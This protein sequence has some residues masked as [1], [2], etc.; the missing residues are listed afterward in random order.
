MS[1]VVD[2][3]SKKYHGATDDALK[4]VSFTCNKGILGLLGPNGAGKTTLMRILTTLLRPTSGRAEIQGH[5]V[6]SEPSCV[7]SLIGYVP[8]E[9]QLY[10]HLTAWEFLS[11]MATLSD[12]HNFQFRIEQ[13]MKQV[14]L[15][16]SVVDRR[17]L[18]TFSGGMKQRV[19]IAQALLHQPQVLL[20]DEPTV[21]LDPAE[22]VRFRNM[23][24]ELGQERTVLFSTHIVEDVASTCR[25]LVILHQGR[26][27]FMGEVDNLISLAE[28]KVWEHKVTHSKGAEL[29]RTVHVISSRPESHSGF[30]RLRF[31]LLHDKPPHGAVP[32]DPTIEDAYLLLIAAEG[33][34]HGKVSQDISKSHTG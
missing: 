30:V 20:V 4:E 33:F 19:A 11:Y 3:I 2:K 15:S 1:I 12:V 21:G 13:V 32:V 14:G 9:Y 31:L 5:D 7:R 22:R 25:R 28:G 34:H 6:V 17:R 16:S 8:Q 10:S 23:L 29:Q 24:I 27:V 18:S 26:L